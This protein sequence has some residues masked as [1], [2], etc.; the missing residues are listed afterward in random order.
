MEIR[1]RDTHRLK[2]R[3]LARCCE[4]G[5]E[6]PVLVN[7]GTLLSLLTDPHISKLNCSVKFVTC[8]STAFQIR[9]LVYEYPLV[10]SLRY[11]SALKLYSR[12]EREDWPV[13]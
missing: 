7:N 4:C 11:D 12:A 13:E 2:E 10:C 1:G 8:S 3:P 6:P 9:A 5:N